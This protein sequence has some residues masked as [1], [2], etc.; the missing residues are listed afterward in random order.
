MYNFLNNFV[1]HFMYKQ[2]LIYSG[3]S[4]DRDQHPT[5]RCD[6]VKIH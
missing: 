6:M 3:Y 1:N 5:V 2:L 4:S